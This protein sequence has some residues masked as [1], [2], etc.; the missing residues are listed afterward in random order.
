M[1]QNVSPV[2]L[3]GDQLRAQQLLADGER[4]LDIG[5]VEEAMQK[6]WECLRL[7]PDSAPAHNKLGV[8]Y[9]RLQQWEKA[10]EQFLTALSI[11]AAYAPAH[12]NMGNLHREAG[13]LDDAVAAY[14]EALRH[15]PDYYIAHH[16][17][18]VV[19][20]Q[21]GKIDEAVSHLKR[22]TGWSERMLGHNFQE[23]PALHL[24]QT[25]WCGSLPQHCSSICCSGERGRA[26]TISFCLL[27][28]V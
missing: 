2:E 18:G 10:R 27:D 26:A 6:F 7:Q 13:R 19:Y 22:G 28:E 25:Y 14:M 9:A 20:K 1:E 17:L 24:Q 4:L 23:A 12:S 15:D 3:S 16:N 11:D 5:R 8:C 21:Q